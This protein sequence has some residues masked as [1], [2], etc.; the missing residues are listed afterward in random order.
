MHIFYQAEEMCGVLYV[1]FEKQTYE[2]R[3]TRLLISDVSVE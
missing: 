3:G 2:H 1:L